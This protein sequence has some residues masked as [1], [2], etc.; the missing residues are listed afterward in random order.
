MRTCARHL[1]TWLL[2]LMAATPALAAASPAPGYSAA[3]VAAV[4]EFH[5]GFR[6]NAPARVSA[7]LGPSFVIFNGNFSADP[8][9]WQAHLY[10]T[11]SRLADWP[12]NFLR[13]AG[14]YENVVRIV[15]V[16][17]RNDAAVVVAEET[18]HNRWRSWDKEIV[19]YL[20]GRDEGRW[21]LVGYFIRDIANPE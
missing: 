13:E 7:V 10:R 6:R 2:L 1:D 18:G 15:R 3:A 19:T 4:E 9:T 20:V 17:L 5:E 16:H 12:G 14:P 11:G 21:R 8:R